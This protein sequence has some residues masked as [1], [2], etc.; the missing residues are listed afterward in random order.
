MPNASPTK[1][2][3]PRATGARPSTGFYAVLAL[4]LPPAVVAGYLLKSMLGINLMPGPSP[5]HDLFYHLVR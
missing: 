1:Q 5:L 3:A 2:T 4:S